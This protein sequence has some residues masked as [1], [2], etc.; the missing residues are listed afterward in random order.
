M[1]CSALRHFGLTKGFM[2][3]K[4][5]SLQFP[6]LSW[7]QMIL[8]VTR[9]RNL[10]SIPVSY[11][12]QAAHMQKILLGT[13]SKIYHESGSFSILPALPWS[14]TWITAVVASC[15]LWFNPC[16]C[17]SKLCSSYSSQSDTFKYNSSAVV[18]LQSKS[19]SPH[20]GQQSC[21]RSLPSFPLCSSLIL[22]HPTLA[23]WPVLKHSMFL[24]CSSC[25]LHLDA[26]SSEFSH[27]RVLLRSDRL[28]PS[29][30]VQQPSPCPGTSDLSHPA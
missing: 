6:H 10:R 27:L 9:A 18:T 23:T 29:H 24:L 12:P 16:P 17:P 8:S 19:Q 20:H 30:V 22:L 3:S 4:L 15:L 14:I 21:T 1:R 7:W 26:P 2:G 25:F 28:W 5:L 11:F 13:S